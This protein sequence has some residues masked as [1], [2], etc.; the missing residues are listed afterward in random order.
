M[1]KITSIMM[2]SVR[3]QV[4]GM[5]RVAVSELTEEEGKAL[6]LLSRSHDMV[7]I[8]AS[9]LYGQGVSLGSAELANKFQKQQLVAVY[10]HE[11]IVYELGEI[12]R[13]L[14]EHKISHIPLKGAVMRNFYPEGWMRTSADIDVLVKPEELD[15]AIEA[16][17]N[18]L[19][20]SGEKRD[21]HDVSMFSPSGVHLELH[22]DTVEE[23]RA[24]N[25]NAVLS[26]FWEHSSPESEGGYTYV[27]DDAM[28]Y[29]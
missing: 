27:T 19:E 8:V 11:S 28:F 23:G 21:R 29:F 6:Y 3:T 1:N 20:Y 15:A 18:D 9:E 5:P 22:F 16:L 12:C 26:E 14:S 7:H 2:S 13:T 25:S 17:K 4:L 10:R 24:V